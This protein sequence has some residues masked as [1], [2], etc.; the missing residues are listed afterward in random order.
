MSL[1]IASQI[2]KFT[3][4]YKHQISRRRCRPEGNLVASIWQFYCLFKKKQ[5]TLARAHNRDTV[6]L[7]SHV[8]EPCTLTGS[9]L[10]ALLSRDFQQLFGQI[11]SLRVMTLSSTNLVAS[12]QFKVEKGSLPV[13]RPSL[14]NVAA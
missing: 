3:W 5:M 12:R 9:G 13:W 6:P 14:K 10:F 4:E 11:V 2:S 7:S 8:F 1:R